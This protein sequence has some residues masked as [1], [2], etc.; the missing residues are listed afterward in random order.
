MVKFLVTLLLAILIF[1]P[2]CLLASKFFRLS[3]QAK[4]NFQDLVKEIRDLAANGKDGETRN[5]LVI[6]DKET[7]ISILDGENEQATGSLASF[8]NQ[9]YALSAKNDINGRTYYYFN[10]PKD[11]CTGGNCIC[12]CRDVEFKN[13][14][15]EY[16]NNF[17]LTGPIS[18][19]EIPCNEL[20]CADLSDIEINKYAFRRSEDQVDV[21]RVNIN[22]IKQGDK[23]VINKGGEE[24]EC[25]LPLFKEDYY[26]DIDLSVDSCGN[27]SAA[28]DKY[29]KIF[30]DFKY[31][32]RLDI[33]LLPEGEEIDYDPSSRLGYAE[34]V[35][36]D[37]EGKKGCAETGMFCYKIIVTE[38]TCSTNEDCKTLHPNLNNP[39]CSQGNCEEAIKKDPD[40]K[41]VSFT[42]N[43]D[44]N[45]VASSDE[46]FEIE[47]NEEGFVELEGSVVIKNEGGQYNVKTVP[48][49]VSFDL[50][51]GAICGQ[52][53]SKS[54]PEGPNTFNDPYTRTEHI[55]YSTSPINAREFGVVEEKF[56]FGKQN[57]L[58]DCKE[59]SCSCRLEVTF[60]FPE[61]L[62][63]P[64]AEPINLVLKKNE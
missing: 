32:C 36:D 48:P 20:L 64:I 47:V 50:C 19:A 37:W 12:L 31:R 35:R 51:S 54:T 5:F 25:N 8:S 39:V 3:N 40:F 13:T 43:K 28:N 24:I 33:P 10:Y 55:L 4:D 57:D 2:G 34:Y 26:D 23:V 16:S 17:Q 1:A 11:T 49:K 6:I 42:L 63:I 21:R 46:T 27:P 41:L 53:Y 56:Y 14:F 15:I 44:G 9:C 58:C 18:V 45:K 38:K 22:L 30:Q 29:K 7:T 62:D 59:S 60:I 61:G 52:P